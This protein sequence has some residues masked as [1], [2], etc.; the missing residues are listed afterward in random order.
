MSSWIAEYVWLSGQNSHHDIRSKCK[1]MTCEPNPPLSAYPVWNFDGSST[2]QALGEDTEILIRPVAVYPHPFLKTANSKVVLC[3]CYK[4]DGTPTPDNTRYVA[5]AV[6]DQKP[7]EE[8]WFGL[9]QEYVLFSKGRP[10]KWPCD[11]YPAPQGE[12]YC[13]NGQTAAWGRDIANE[14]YE[15]CLAMGLKLSGVNA[16]VMPGQWEYQVGPCLGIESGD[17]TVIARWVYLRIGE[18]YGVDINFDS[19]PIKGDWNGSGLHTNFSTKA[20]RAPGGLAA[21]H[22][23]IERL[24]GTYLNDIKF[25]GTD[26]DERL[27]GKH[28]TSSVGKFSFGVGTR[29]TSIRIPN[30]AANNKSGYFEDRRPAA[31]AD[32]YLITATLFASS[33]GITSN[34]DAKKLGVWRSWMASL[35]TA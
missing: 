8:P 29:H 30:E 12:Y 11:G 16:E 1:T 24:R 31:S 22:A 23:A 7:E 15:T 33:T 26:N 27:T 18:K 21:I 19:K 20:M 3:E 13:G 4:P 6:F 17:H 2:K 10:Y 35:P 14:H 34:F 25:Y 32:P 5:R 28:E 9:E